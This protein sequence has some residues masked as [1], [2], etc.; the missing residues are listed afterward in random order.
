MGERALSAQFV[1]DRDHEPGAIVVTLYGELDLAS[2]PLLEDELHA[3]E[4]TGKERIVIDLSGLDF[5]DSV[6]LEVLI[7]AQRRS[8]QNGHQLS[9][10]R[11]SRSVHRIFELTNMEAAFRFDD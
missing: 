10:L 4:T 11:G 2:G 8:L 7:D 5:M 3:A 6:G 9:L 1:I